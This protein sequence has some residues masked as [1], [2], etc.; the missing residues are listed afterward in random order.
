MQDARDTFFVALRT[1]LAAINPD[2][3][4]VLRG[5]IRPGVLVEENELPTAFQPTDAFTLHW[6]AMVVDAAGPLPLVAMEC[7]INYAT[8]GTS[9]N[10]GMDRGRLLGAMDGEL[11]AALVTETQSAVKKNLSGVAGTGAAA[12][13]MATNIFWSG[14]QFAPVKTA[15]ERLERTA[16]V[17]LFSYQEAG[18]L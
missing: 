6:T 3:T 15:G 16:T 7:Q 12:V 18:E 4:I 8:D 17:Q 13:A 2:R 11:T 1:R 10:G 14:P 5:Q 9:G